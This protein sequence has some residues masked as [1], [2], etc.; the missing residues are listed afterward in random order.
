MDALVFDI[1]TI[2]DTALG[3]RLYD[4]P[5]SA[6]DEAVGHIMFQK[7]LEKSGSSFLPHYQ[8]RVIAISVVYQTPRQFRVFSIGESSSPEADLIQQFFQAIDKKWPTIIS[9]NGQGFDLPVLQYRALKHGIVS[10]SYWDNGEKDQRLKWNNYRNRFHQRHVD[11]MDE[12]S[13]YQ[14]RSSAPLDGIAVMLGL[15][16]KQGQSGKGVWDSYLEGDITGIRNYC[17]TDVL[18]TYLVY[19]QYALIRGHID[20]ASYQTRLEEVR[21]FLNCS[22]NLHWQEFLSGWQPKQSVVVS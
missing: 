6:T 4:L 16:G 13:N 12:L 18:N 17:E 19:L 8:H 11:I 14:G 3:R 20:N 7:S 22:D 2:P 21:S 1:E 5:D 9:W 15:P 10:E